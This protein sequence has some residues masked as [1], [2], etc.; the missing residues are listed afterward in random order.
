MWYL[1]NMTHF[2]SCWASGETARGLR[3]KASVADIWNEAVPMRATPPPTT[4]Q[5]SGGK[6]I[7]LGGKKFLYPA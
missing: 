2:E 5:L 1:S 3:L 6:D 7:Q 4:S